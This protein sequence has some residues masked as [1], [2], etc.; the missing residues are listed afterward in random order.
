M[1]YNKEEESQIVNMI[2]ETNEDIR[3]SLYEQY[4]PMIGFLVKKYISRANQLGLETNDLYQEALVGFTDALNNYDEQ[5]DASLRTF[6]SLCIERRLQKVLEKANR[7]KNKINQEMLSL[8]YEY[9]Q[10]ISLLE[11]ISDTTSDPLEKFSEQEQIDTIEEKIKQVLSTN[12]YIVYEDMKKGLNYLEIAKKL[13]KS[14]K[15]I[16]NTIQRLKTK[17]KL[18]LKGEEKWKLLSKI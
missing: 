3:N 10:G 18:I 16:D 13:D 1:K 4:S 17:V 14:P 8:D 2:C 7:L 11:T 6:V 15:Q 9:Q 5:K 12:E